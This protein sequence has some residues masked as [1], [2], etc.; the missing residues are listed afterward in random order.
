MHY[1]LLTHKPDLADDPTKPAQT[2]T[3]GLQTVDLVITGHRLHLVTAALVK[4]ELAVLRA[5]PDRYAELSPKQP[6]IAKIEVKAL[7][8]G[9]A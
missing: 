4:N 6:Y 7:N 9:K 3:I 2:L 5:I 8:D 1:Q